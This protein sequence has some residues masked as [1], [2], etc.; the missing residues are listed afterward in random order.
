MPKTYYEK[1]ADLYNSNTV[2]QSRR[3]STEYGDPFSVVVELPPPTEEF[4]MQG[5][6]VK[7][8]MIK[9]RGTFLGIN[10]GM[11]ASGEGE[12]SLGGHDLKCFVTGPRTGKLAN[13][14]ATSYC[15]LTLEQNQELD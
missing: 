2:L 1:V 5:E 14:D 9:L 6:S 4:Q 7:Q 3:F 11:K 12:G 10:A 13:G 15:I 8:K